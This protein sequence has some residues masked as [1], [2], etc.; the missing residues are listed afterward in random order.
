MDIEGLNKLVNTWLSSQTNIPNGLEIIIRIPI[1]NSANKTALVTAS[2]VKNKPKL[3]GDIIFREIYSTRTKNA[4]K[5][6]AGIDPNTT[7]KNFFKK[8]PN[9][10]MLLRIPDIGRRGINEILEALHKAGYNWPQ[11]Y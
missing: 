11:D 9:Q 10:Y 2:S 4:L 5:D 3:C 8:Y 7:I 1:N 6:N